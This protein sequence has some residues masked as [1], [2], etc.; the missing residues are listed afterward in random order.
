MSRY[1]RANIDGGTPDHSTPRRC[2][3][4]FLHGNDGGDRPAFT[5]LN[6]GNAVRLLSTRLIHFLENALLDRGTFHD[7]FRSVAGSG[8]VLRAGDRAVVFADKIHRMR[9][10][11]HF[12]RG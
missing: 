2:C 6:P 8:Y 7:A 11:P 9:D 5:S 1:R 10:A 3:A 12:G 4:P